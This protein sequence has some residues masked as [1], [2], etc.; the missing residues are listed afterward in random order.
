MNDLNQIAELSPISDAEASQFVPDRTH[1]DLIAAIISTP[2]RS[3]ARQRSK[4]RRLTARTPMARR[5]LVAVP[6]VLGLAGAVLIANLIGRPGE[7]VGPINVGLPKAKA[8]LTFTKHGHF[9]DVI[10]TNPYA[11]KKKYDGEFKAHGLRIKLQLVAASPSLVDT[12][13]YFSGTGNFSGIKVITQKGRCFTGGAGSNCPVGI[14]VPL[15][16]RGT[17]DF[18]FGRPARPGEQY[19][20]TA[21]AFAPGEALHGLHIIGHRVGAVLAL[22]KTRHVTVAVYHTLK[23]GND[24][25]TISKA[26]SNWYVYDAIPWAKGKALLEVGKTRHQPSPGPPAP[27]TPVPTPSPTGHSPTGH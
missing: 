10:V 23:H 12:T 7:H 26:P 4:A 18:A 14:R 27:G 6:V 20:T 8:A 19:E 1:A 2:S 24:E 9:I 16:F 11:D 5:W 3:S 17:A 13:V 22:M 25:V 21:S 15:N